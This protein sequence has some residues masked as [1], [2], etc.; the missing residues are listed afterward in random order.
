VV[1]AWGEEAVIVFVLV[2][3]AV[4]VVGLWAFDVK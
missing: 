1:A 4:V 3:L 2:V